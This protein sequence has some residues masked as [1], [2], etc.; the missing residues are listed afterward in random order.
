[1][2]KWPGGRVRADGPGKEVF[3]LEKRH[4][5]HRYTIRLEAGNEEQA[6]VELALFSRHPEG[7]RTQ[8]QEAREASERAA[9]ISVEAAASF[10]E[11]LKREGRTERYRSDAKSYLAQWAEFYDSRE[12]AAVVS[13]PTQMR[14]AD[15]QHESLVLH[16][17]AQ[18]GRR[19]HA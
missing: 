18:S 13:P 6:M 12:W 8:K 3:V 14:F 1:L 4:G 2:R 17:R 19:R 5:D 15:Q 9:L 7:Y 10:L 16:R 11:H